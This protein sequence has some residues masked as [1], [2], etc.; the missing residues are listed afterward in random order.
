MALAQ[1]EFTSL[2]LAG[3]LGGRNKRWFNGCITHSLLL[4]LMM[5]VLHFSSVASAN[6]TLAWNPSTDPQ[7]AGFNIYYGGV[8][9]AYT[10]KTSV[11]TTTSLMVSN[12]V[13]GATY[14]FA[15]TTYNAAGS[16]SAFSS[17]VSYTVP[18]LPPVQLVV[19]PAKQLVLTLTGPVGSNYV[20]QAST[21]L[22]HWAPFSTNII[23][24]GG[25]VT[26][27]DPNL[28]SPQ[29]YYRAVPYSVPPSPQLSG[30]KMS[31]GIFSFVLAG[32]VGSN[33][34]IQAS[35]DLVHWTPFSTNTLP[36]GGSVSIVDSNAVSPRKFY[37]ALPYDVASV[38]QLPQLS[39]FKMSNG[40]FSFILTGQAGYTYEIQASQDFKAW[41]VIGTVTTGADGSVNFADTNAVVFSRR[42]YRSR[43]T[44][45]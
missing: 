10:N 37:R 21:D 38:M 36:P 15:A 41:T 44:V 39:G 23:P 29:K 13:P 20:L 16:E 5:A 19:T 26:I 33:Y 34:V 22:V 42:F 3:A 45:P 40:I 9:G 18:P 4:G 32:P 28:A 31:K 7:V 17:E 35:T 30:S 1:S 25:S 8:S 14:Y 43:E 6:V 12:L 24:P 11:G 27:I 2:N